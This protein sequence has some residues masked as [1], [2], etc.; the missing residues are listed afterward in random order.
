MEAVTYA[1]AS[2]AIYHSAFM[3][4][5]S[6]VILSTTVIDGRFDH[7]GRKMWK[8]KFLVETSVTLTEN[9]SSHYGYS[10]TT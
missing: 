2:I 6:S 4:A 9:S 5:K 7:I 8:F 1:E 3:T 10:Y